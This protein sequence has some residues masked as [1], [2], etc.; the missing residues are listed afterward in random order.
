MFG[1]GDC[2]LLTLR[3]GVV[4]RVGFDIL[5]RLP[6]RRAESSP[7]VPF[8]SADDARLG[9]TWMHCQSSEVQA[10]SVTGQQSREPVLY[11]PLYNGVDGYFRQV[12]L[13]YL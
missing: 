12:T 9:N 7:I 13:T 8:D 1:A 5:L 2:R 3:A 6:A 4:L 10:L 11:G